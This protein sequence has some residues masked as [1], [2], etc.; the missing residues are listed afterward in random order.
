M[1]A[2]GMYSRISGGNA[3]EVAGSRSVRSSTSQSTLGAPGPSSSRIHS[4]GSV[5]ASQQ[6]TLAALNAEDEESAGGEYGDGV[7]SLQAQNRALQADLQDKN[8]YISTLEKRLLQ[9]RRSSHSRMSM[10]FSS[11][12]KGGDEGEIFML[13]QEKD[14]EI[15][16]LRARLDDKERM[17]SALRSAARKRE[18]AELTPDSSSGEYK[19]GSQDQSHGSKTDTMSSNSSPI[20]SM[21]PKGFLSPP[22]A[23]LEETKRR[24]VDEMSKMLDEMIQDKVESG[25]IVKGRSGSVRVAA[26]HSRR[27]SST[28]LRRLSTTASSPLPGAV[29]TNL[30]EGN[31]DN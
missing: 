3:P 31:P 21:S 24:S 17:V 7:A 11:L 29:A 13:M 4:M 30:D 1:S 15:A 23:A 10:G 25:H 22:K 2:L 14:T 20:K 16:D 27:Q 9:A 19:K 5:T 6:R 8:R 12:K 26:G 28:H 18:V